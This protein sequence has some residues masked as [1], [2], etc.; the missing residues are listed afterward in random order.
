MSG[1]P[2]T[3]PGN[4]GY[5]RRKLQFAK[6]AAKTDASGKPTGSY[7]WVNY[8]NHKDLETFKI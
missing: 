2:E 8:D 6:N 7:K 4:S 5:R 1:S 3:P